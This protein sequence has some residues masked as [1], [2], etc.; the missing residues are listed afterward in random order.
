MTSSNRRKNAVSSA[1]SKIR[2]KNHKPI[3][4]ISLEQFKQCVSNAVC[5]SNVVSFSTLL[6]E[7]V[8]LI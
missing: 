7:S 1:E 2:C 8:A 6:S 4:R 5:L 3:A